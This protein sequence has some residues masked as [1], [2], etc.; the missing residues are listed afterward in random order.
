MKINQKIQT[1]TYP[2]FEPDREI[3]QIYS[4]LANETSKLSR[5][6]RMSGFFLGRP[7][8]L[9]PLGEGQTGRFDQNPLYRTDAFDCLT[10]VNTVLALF[11]A[12]NIESFREKMIAINYQDSI[13]A[14][15]KRYHFMNVDWNKG[16]SR[17]GLVEEVTGKIVD[18]NNRSVAVR[19]ETYIDKP[20]WFRHR[21]LSD[22]KLLQSIDE[23][24]GQNL[25]QE[26]R[27]MADQVSG[28][29][30]VLDYLPLSILF[31]EFQRPNI[32][33]FSQIPDGAI[34][35]IVRPNWD[36]RET[37]GTCLDISHLGFALYQENILMFRDASTI[38]KKVRDIPL[39][40][41]LQNYLKSP[42]IKGIHVLKICL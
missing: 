16:N 39:I 41:Y 38:E 15:E 32:S 12:K 1:P 24:S 19:S 34:I 20:E 30:S 42:T 18:E 27:E 2:R 9:G 11:F 33:L 22:I 7:Y 25:L 23:Q 40:D 35:E 29:I 31:D 28:E 3:D 13:I 14:Y 5:F 4:F 37:I 8:L 26:L 17:L 6:R 21:Q 10:Y 36:L